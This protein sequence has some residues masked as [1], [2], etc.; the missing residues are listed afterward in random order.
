MANLVGRVKAPFSS[1]LFA[2]TLTES[3]Y[4]G[5]TPVPSRSIYGTPEDGNFPIWANFSPVPLSLFRAM[6]F[7]PLPSFRIAFSPSFDDGGE[8]T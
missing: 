1:L 7:R 4:G 5:P 6:N 8:E 2:L 3:L